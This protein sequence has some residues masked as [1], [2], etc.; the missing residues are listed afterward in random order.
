MATKKG[1]SL[2]FSLPGRGKYKLYYAGTSKTKPATAYTGVYETIGMTIS[3]PDI[4]IEPIPATT[5]SWVNVKYD[6]NWNTEAVGEVALWHEQA[7]KDGDNYRS[8]IGSE[9]SCVAPGVVELN[10]KVE[11]SDISSTLWT[12]RSGFVWWYLRGAYVKTPAGVET[13]YSVP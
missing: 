2:T 5:Q 11:N 3:A 1:S 6:V 8:Y 9:H 10:H 4:T 13:D 7:F 12:W